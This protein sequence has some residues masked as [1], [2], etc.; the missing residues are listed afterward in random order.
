MDEDLP[1]KLRL[2]LPNHEVST[3]AYLGWKGLKNGELLRVAEDAGFEVLVT[4]D[5]NL[6]YQQNLTGRRIGIVLLPA[7]EWPMLTKRVVEIASAADEALPGSFRVVEW[8]GSR[9][10]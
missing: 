5:Q 3:V 6:G 10:W 7:Q 4:G 9:T 8:S 2:S 1:H